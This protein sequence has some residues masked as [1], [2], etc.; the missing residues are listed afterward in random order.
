MLSESQYVV[1]CASP[2][3]LEC[4]MDKKKKLVQRSEGPP[5]MHPHASQHRNVD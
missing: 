3:F 2:S 4:V 5:L 1:L